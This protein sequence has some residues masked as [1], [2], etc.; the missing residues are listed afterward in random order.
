MCNTRK[1]HFIRFTIMCSWNNRN[2]MTVNRRALICSIVKWSSAPGPIPVISQICAI[3]LFLLT[4]IR[5]MANGNYLVGSLY[6]FALLSFF[7]RHASQWLCLNKPLC[8]N[9]N[10]TAGNCLEILEKIYHKLYCKS[11]DSNQ[12]VEPNQEP[13]FILVLIF[14]TLFFH[15]TRV[16]FF[17][18]L[19]WLP[20]KKQRSMQI[21]H[22]PSIKSPRSSV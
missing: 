15:F 19:W 16:P 7:I 20:N 13:S 5:P 18:A 21:S 22:K 3:R 1:E 2:L 11:S 6:L 9:G 12:V 17:L 4:P 8:H 14:L 10:A